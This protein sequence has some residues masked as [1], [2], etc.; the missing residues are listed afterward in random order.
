MDY[1]TAVMDEEE[2]NSGEPCANLDTL[3]PK[4]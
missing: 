1:E 3:F 4:I 2:K